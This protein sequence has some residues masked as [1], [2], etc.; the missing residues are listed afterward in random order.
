[1]FWAYNDWEYKIDD[2]DTKGDGWIVKPDPVHNTIKSTIRLESLRDGIE[3]WELL[4]KI[5]QTKP[6]LAK[7]FV[8]ALV[9][10]ATRYSQDTGFITRMHNALVSAAAGGQV[11]ATNL[12]AGGTI[13]ASSSASGFGPDK[14]IDLDP[15]TSWKS[16]GGGTQWWQAALPQQAQ[17]DGVRLTWGAS[18][19]TSFKVQLSYDGTK[20]SDA[21]SAASVSGS[22]TF[23]GINGKAKFVRVSGSCPAAGCSIAELQIGGSPL[24]PENLAGGKAYDKT[25]PSADWPDNNNADATDGVLAGQYDDHRSFGYEV[26]QNGTLT[27]TVTVDLQ[28]VKSVGEVKIHRYGKYEQKYDPDSLVLATSTDKVTFTQKAS[29][30]GANGQDGLWYDLTFPASQARYV[31]V[32]FKKKFG[33]IQ[34]YL[35]L[36]EIEAYAP[37]A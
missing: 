32:T 21:Y 2:Q 19:P 36:D 16:S 31:R 35:F 28:A 14:A 33:P 10:S 7:S 13:T 25:T 27:V 29:A 17:I 22:D 37:P 15:A 11:F 23:A 34:D 30:Q 24:A 9:T 26:P 8:Q 3:D 12:A 5:G 1:V 4:N 18:A 20:W 6:A